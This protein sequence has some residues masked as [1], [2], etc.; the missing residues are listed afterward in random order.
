MS[1]SLN[2]WD[3]EIEHICPKDENSFSR[4]SLGDSDQ[5]VK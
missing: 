5:F 3:E 2:E 1:R 4:Y